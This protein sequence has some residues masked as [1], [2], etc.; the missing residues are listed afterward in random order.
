VVATLRQL[1]QALLVSHLLW[2]FAVNSAAVTATERM[3]I[4]SSGNV[5]I[6]TGSPSKKLQVAGD[7]L[8]TGTDGIGLIPSTNAG[9]IYISRSS[10]QRNLIW[11]NNTTVI[12]QCGTV[13]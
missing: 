10:D 13:F 8:M 9:S 12:A 1:T 2:F 6:G 4:D 3:R 11:W 5:G 7:I